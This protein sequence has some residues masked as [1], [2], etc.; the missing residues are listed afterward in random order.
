MTICFNDGEIKTFKDEEVKVI[1]GMNSLSV[2][3]SKD[4][5]T[6]IPYSSIRRAVYP[7][8]IIVSIHSEYSDLEKIH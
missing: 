1:L 7:V 6:L 4:V 2:V 8:S 5:T 3:D